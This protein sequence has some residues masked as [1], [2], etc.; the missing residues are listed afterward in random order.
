[1]SKIVRAL[2]I[3]AA[4][5]GAF[6]VALTLVRGRAEQPA[7]AT[8]PDERAPDALMVDADRMPEAQRD[9]LLDELA[10]QL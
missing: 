4:A 5:T 10:A 7:P 6:A 2:L 9:A 1:M 8:P 3:S